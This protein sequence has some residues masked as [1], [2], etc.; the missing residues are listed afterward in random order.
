[1]KNYRTFTDFTCAFPTNEACLSYLC[2]LKWGG[3]FQCLRCSHTTYVKGRTWYYRR[4]QKCGYDES[5]TAQTLFHK[6][7]FPL[8]KAFCIIY[9][10]GTMKKGMST[11]EISR[12]YGIHQETAWFF[13]RKVQQAM[14]HLHRGTTGS[15][16]DGGG[17]VLEM[18]RDGRSER[19]RKRVKLVNT[20]RK[21]GDAKDARSHRELHT[22]RSI[23]NTSLPD[24][25]R[26]MAGMN[27]QFLEEM[28]HQPQGS[29]QQKRHGQFCTFYSDKTAPIGAN[30]W[31]L[32]NLKN[33][34][35]G[36]HHRV[37][38]WHSPFYLDEYFYRFNRRK[39]ISASMG[40]LVETMI[41]LPWMS[42]KVL[43][44][45]ESR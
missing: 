32:F 23:T 16:A 26:A 17:S 3:G 41:V 2:D 25:K 18:I 36:T 24:L 19:V 43:T 10:L 30:N 5:C 31:R 14:N 38:E 12:Q 20:G 4:C 9:Q 37:S 11:L 15:A 6:I 13:K 35:M 22:A 33:W 39:S 44:C 42:Y 27:K 45:D 7:K 40:Q 28:S 21:P 29:I 8:H 34:L 1:M